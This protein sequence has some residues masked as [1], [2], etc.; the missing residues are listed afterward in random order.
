M[1]KHATTF[2]ALCLAAGCA[3]NDMSSNSNGQN[4]TPSAQNTAGSNLSTMDRQFIHDAA[5][6]GMT[7]VQ[8][9]QIASNKAT[10]GDLRQFAQ[11]MVT[12]HQNANNQLMQ[13][14]QQKGVTVPSYLDS[15]GQSVIDKLNSV[16]GGDFDD[17]YIT[18][19]VKAHVDTIK[20]FESEANMGQDSDVKGWASKTLPTLQHH[21]EMIK[22]L[23]SSVGTAGSPESNKRG[24]ETPNAPVVPPNQA[25]G[26]NQPAPQT[27][28]Q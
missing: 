9:G 14:A 12:D 5:V 13:L 10:S 3:S 24:P 17:T 1:L 4:G 20:L 6:G 18:G 2:A 15:D 22:G 26:N 11:Q 27:P 19:Q 23:Q 7:E 25:T 21:L 8:A 28:Q 16:N